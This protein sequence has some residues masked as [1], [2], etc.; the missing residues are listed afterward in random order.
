MTFII[1]DSCWSL[2]FIVSYW[3]D[4]YDLRGERIVHPDETDEEL[5]GISDVMFQDFRTRAG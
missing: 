1:P 2:M 4:V 3:L 5:L